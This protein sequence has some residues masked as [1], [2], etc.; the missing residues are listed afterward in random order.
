M[1]HKLQMLSMLAAATLFAQ[2]DTSGVSGFIR[3]AS[4]ALV[5]HA[6]V[7]VRDEAT[8]R[9]RRT[10]TDA[11]GYF[12]LSNL[13]AGFY[14]VRVEAAGFRAYEESRRKID[15]NLAVAVA[16]RLT[17]GS[18]QDS[19]NVVAAAAE[20]QSETATV[21]RMVSAEQIANLQ[22]NG[23]NPILLASLVPGVLRGNSISSF[24][25]N[26]DNNVVINGARK[27][28][29]NIT[30]DGAPAVRTRSAGVPIGVPDIDSTQ[31]VQ[32]LTASYNAEY[33][34]ASGGQIR[35][36][37]KSGTKDFHGSFYE[38]IRNSALDANTW[39]RNASGSKDLAS[40]I[41]FR[42]NQFG[43][44]LSGPVLV[45]GTHFNSGRNKLFWLFG[46]EWVK[47]RRE[48]TIMRLVPSPAIRQGNFSELLQPSNIYYGRAV[49]VRDP[50]TGNPFPGNVIPT[51]QLSTNG[52]G[53]LRA[54]PLP[55][56]GFSQGGANWF[57]SNSAPQNQRKD[58]ASM[59]Y[60]PAEKHYF[61]FRL[62]NYNYDQLVP[63]QGNYDRGGRILDRPNQVG[64]LNYIWT[65]SPTMV[66]ELLISASHD[67][68]NLILDPSHK[69]WE[70]TQYGITYPYLFPVGKIVQ[71]LIPAV[72]IAGLA[73]MSTAAV[74]TT[75][76]PIY[77]VSDNF[78]RI[79]QRHVVKAG[80]VFEKAGQNDN[81]QGVQSG[82]F[83]FSDSRTGG[84][85][86]GVAMA[87]AALGLFDSYS[88]IGAYNYV[89]YRGSM[90]EYFIQ[91][92]WKATP[93]LHIEF[94]IRHSLIQPW[95]SEWRNIAM[96]NPRFYD[97][98]Q[99]PTLDPRT[100]RLLSAP[101]FNGIVI[102][103]DG[104]PDSAQGRLLISNLDSLKPLF[105]G[106]GK[107]YSPFH[108]KD[109]QPRL[110]LAYSPTQRLVIRAAAGRY[111]LRPSISDNVNPGANPP[112]QQSA[113]IAIGSVDSPAGG[114][115][116][117][118]APLLGTL[119]PISHNP[120][121][122][123]WN[124]TVE[125]GISA[126]TTVSAG[127]VG[128]RGIHSLFRDRNLNQLRAGTIQRN[129]GINVNAL[130]PYQGYG[131]IRLTSNDAYSRYDGMQMSL[132]RRTSKG[133]LIGVAYTFAQTLD[134]GSTK[135]DILPDAYD[136]SKFWGPSAD[137][138]RHVL[139]ANFLWEIPSPAG[140]RGV[141]GGVLKGW[142]L[143]GISQFQTGR[144]FTISSG[145]DIAGVGSGGG[146]QIFDVN[147]NP[148]LPRS[149]RRFANS[150]AD[151]SF[152]FTTTSN[153]QPIFTA[154]AAGTFTT[155]RNRNLLHGP[156]FQSWN[157]SLAK[158]ISLVER[159]KIQF[160]FEAFNW[161]NHP[162]WNGPGTNPRNLTT[163][164]K[165][166]SKSSER[167]LQMSLRYSF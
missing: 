133:L 140:L 101:N 74:G 5:P 130:R 66:N 12:V 120:S 95:Y 87:N 52:I 26:M 161:P 24:V 42:F 148:F 119:D 157:L 165:V 50:N 141:A 139:V 9:E 32:I 83:G 103:G 68:T 93:K 84:S 21:G 156:G 56:A 123:M 104:F 111:V 70:R 143:S 31:E 51:S 18:T 15:A 114:T 98:A 124:S 35:I 77:M 34:R 154:P 118:N 151:S 57:T 159:H 59:D 44:S 136:A 37:T 88:E 126:S 43:F 97:P 82:T 164:G 69:R 85:T 27:E 22:L 163:L 92:S 160:R 109:F 17:V 65:V 8:N 89:P 60:I 6:Q 110:G 127:Y 81:N 152:W 71:D 90:F 14:T 146:A 91:D 121:S 145:E 138:V 100:G 115:P 4:D 122:W 131:E 107:S 19:V 10:E 132:N 135:D 117:A 86:S 11:R 128:R 80:V 55:I 62:L 73:L 137:D 167:S 67:R 162:N 78:T 134:N 30:F 113:S 166:L 94:G 102:P 40:P 36:I 112:F 53:L 99:A 125:Y 142:Q 49:V 61:R 155:Q 108:K 48:Q 29:T 147:G 25:F 45:P 46:E 63:F 2:S 39:V 75:A 1:S 23:R 41:P 33:G 38:Y 129:P 76:G 13:P 72:N 105:R 116:L 153:G 28:E 106:L 150:V 144:P 79:H 64:S 47:D 16:I 149:D 3:D 96:F 54:F 7:L 158:Q 20:V 58:T